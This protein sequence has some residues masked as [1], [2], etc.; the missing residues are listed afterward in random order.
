MG[1][2]GSGR[3]ASLNWAVG[4]VTVAVPSEAAGH[5]AENVLSLVGMYAFAS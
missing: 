1:M 2:W 4:Q 3:Q 5:C